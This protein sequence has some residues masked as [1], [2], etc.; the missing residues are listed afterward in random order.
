MNKRKSAYIYSGLLLLAYV[1]LSYLYYR[2]E[3]CVFPNT[4]EHLPVWTWYY[5]PATSI[6]FLFCAF[7]LWFLCRKLNKPF[8]LNHRVFLYILL[9]SAALSVLTNPY[10][11]TTWVQCVYSVLFL[12]SFFL[13]LYGLFGRLFFLFWTPFLLMMGVGVYSALQKINLDSNTILEIISTTAADAAFFLTPLLITLTICLILLS[14]CISY[15]GHYLLRKQSRWSILGTGCF[16]MA[17]FLLLLKPME[18]HMQVGQKFLWPIGGVTHLSYETAKA[19][20]FKL[21]LDELFKYFPDTPCNVDSCDTVSQDDDIICILHIGESVRADHL[22]LNGWHHDTTPH[23]RENPDLINFPTCIAAAP[24]TTKSLIVMLTNARRDYITTRNKNFY[25]SSGSI[26][27]FFSSSG[28]TCKSFWNE[29]DLE[30]EG[31]NPRLIQYFSR[32]AEII[33]TNHQR[34]Q[35]KKIENQLDQHQ[36]GPLM[37]TL[38]NEGSHH[39]YVWYDLSSPTFTPSRPMQANDKPWAEPEK[40]LGLANAYDNTILF[41]ENFIHQ[42]LSKL[43]GKPF[44]YVYVSDHGD[45]MGQ[46]G[47]W[48]RT[49]APTSEF[50]KL[51]ACRVPFFIV[52]SPELLARNPHFAQAADQLKAHQDMK[53]G[54]EHLFHT[55]LGFFNMKTPYYRPELDLCSEQ[56]KPYAGPSPE[57]NGVEEEPSK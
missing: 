39:P 54:H 57:N 35:L 49:N 15:L 53:I 3:T 44:L 12:F 36:R 56:V 18:H 25:P 22:S 21:R 34:D 19:I 37:I 17:L 10:L 51:G 8:T 46:E 32:T 27:D 43:K 26:I 20:G 5:F 55:L 48:T 2:D 29:G 28:F 13:L 31:T 6:V 11:T 40:A 47:Y 52:A 41:T 50:H 33:P 14:L 4:I 42:L 30:R 24:F 9:Y 1:L 16:S 45:Y 23:L 38:Q 7:A